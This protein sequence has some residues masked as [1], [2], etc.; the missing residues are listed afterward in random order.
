[1]DTPIKAPKTLERPGG[2]TCYR[3]QFS[4]IQL[5]RWLQQ[6]GLFPHK[7]YTIGALTVPDQ[8]FRDFLRGHL[9]GDGTITTYQDR[10]NIRKNSAYLYIRFFVRF[11]SASRSHLEWL[12]T[13]IT[14]LTGLKGDFFEIKPRQKNRVSIWQLKFMKKEAI[15]L[16]AWLYYDPD[17]PSLTRKRV[18]AEQAIQLMATTKRKVYTRTA[19]L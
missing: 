10:Y 12:R 13:T 11:I 16:V 3:I 18:K 15:K 17:L 8:F 9:D 19:T 6:I 14:R 5:Y 1:M 4:N 2:N 7:T